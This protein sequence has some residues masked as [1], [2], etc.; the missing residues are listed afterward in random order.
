MTLDAVI[1]R[2][3]VLDARYCEDDDS[4]AINEIEGLAHLALRLRKGKLEDAEGCA[5]GRVWAAPQRGGYG[6]P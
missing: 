1:Q 6:Q 3:T 2:T 4:T 5:K